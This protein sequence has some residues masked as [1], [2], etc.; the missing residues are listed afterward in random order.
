MHN[1]V[2]FRPVEMIFVDAGHLVDLARDRGVPRAEFIAHT[3][4]EEIAERLAA[5]EAA[6]MSGEFAR[7]AKI[8]RSLV[9]MSEQLGMKTLGHVAGELACVAAGRDHAAL[10][11]LIARLVRVGE[12]SLSA[13]GDIALLSR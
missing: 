11:A 9:G 8:A 4:L 3:A 2:P 7:L 10:A 1:V 13:F 12:G 5:A 6:W